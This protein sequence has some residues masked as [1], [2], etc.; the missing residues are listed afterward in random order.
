VTF[1]VQVVDIR[2]QGTGILSSGE[3]A[4]V[5][6]VPVVPP[7]VVMPRGDALTVPAASTAV[8]SPD[9][10][11]APVLPPVAMA[12]PLSR[13][14]ATTDVVVVVV[15]PVVQAPVTGTITVTVSH[16]ETP[17]QGLAGVGADNTSSSTT[18]ASGKITCTV[19]V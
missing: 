12:V 11:R 5:V 3:A 7:V 13:R 16:R 17:L 6:T 15:I 9:V 14:R 2:L 1:L 18:C 4:P 10:P 19:E 8:V